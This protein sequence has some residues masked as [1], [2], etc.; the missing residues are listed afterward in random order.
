MQPLG[1]ILQWFSPSQ[2]STATRFLLFIRVV[3]VLCPLD[4]SQESHYPSR[5]ERFQ[6]GCLA[7][8]L[9]A[10]SVLLD[11]ASQLVA[12]PACVIRFVIYDKIQEFCVTTIPW[13]N[14][15]EFWVCLATLFTSSLCPFIGLRFRKTTPWLGWDIFIE[16]FTFTDFVEFD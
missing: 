13:T 3:C 1:S 2:E 10:G 16:S 7:P 6:Y 4:R 9:N 11:I 8:D 15:I 12:L 5:I 14:G